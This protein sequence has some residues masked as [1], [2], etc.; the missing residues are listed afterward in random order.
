M[1]DLAGFSEDSEERRD[2]YGKATSMKLDSKVIYRHFTRRCLVH[3][4]SGTG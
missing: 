4:T 2:C 3:N 1:V